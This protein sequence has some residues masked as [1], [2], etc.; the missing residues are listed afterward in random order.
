MNVLHIYLRCTS[1]D[2]C[3]TLLWVNILLF[4]SGILHGLHLSVFLNICLLG[5][6]L[7]NTIFDSIYWQICLL[8][9][10]EVILDLFEDIITVL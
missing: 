10:P 1:S 8:N 2:A 5:R 3:T 6:K 9:T 7:V 4:L